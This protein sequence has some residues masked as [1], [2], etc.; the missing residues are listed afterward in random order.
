MSIC[1]NAT[2]HYVASIKNLTK[3]LELDKDSSKALYLRSVAHAKDGN[4]E[5]AVQD[6]AKAIKLNPNDKQLREQLVVAKKA[7][8]VQGVP[9]KKTL[10]KFFDKGIYNEKALPTQPK[11]HDSLPEFDPESVQTFF[12]ITI[13]GE[14]AG[15]VVFEL[16]SREAATPPS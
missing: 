14:A 15:R 10:F 3:A 16:F 5:L 11:T 7:Q 4:G 13:G 8:A 9:D 12:D 1:T 2:G 6:I